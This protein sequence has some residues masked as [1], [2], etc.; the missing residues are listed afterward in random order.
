MTG[1]QAGRQTD[2]LAS[3]RQE[4]VK[5]TDGEGSKKKLT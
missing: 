4:G 1:R 2:K 5:Q 3:G